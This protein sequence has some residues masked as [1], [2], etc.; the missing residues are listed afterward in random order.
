MQHS[1][2]Q[3][4]EKMKSLQEEL[5]TLRQKREKEKEERGRQDREA[6]ALLTQRSERAEE[7]VRQFSLKLQEKVGIQRSWGVMLD[8]EIFEWQRKD[9]VCQ[10]RIKRS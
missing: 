4:Q 5:H 6:L 2:K 3:Q 8:A 10:G 9:Q 7:S 1:H